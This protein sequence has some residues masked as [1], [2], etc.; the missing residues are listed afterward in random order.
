MPILDDSLLNLFFLVSRYIPNQKTKSPRRST[1]KQHVPQSNGNASRNPTKYFIDHA[2]HNYVRGLQES[3]G[4]VETVV[5]SHFTV[6]GL[7]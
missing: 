3:V 1:R 2:E 7:F 5:R 6:R 4:H